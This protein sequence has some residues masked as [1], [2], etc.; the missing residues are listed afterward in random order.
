MIKF[1]SSSNPTIGVEIE[2]QIIDVNTLDLKNLAPKVLSDVDKK[3]SNRIKYELFESMIE[4]NSDICSSVTE[5][6]KD[7]TQS[8]HHLE[9]ILKGLVK[10]YK[11]QR[12]FL[13]ISF[14]TCLNLKK[15]Y[16]FC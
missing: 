9:E 11:L 10:L 16:H 2:L 7:I 14:D 8:L 4:I 15:S 13:K 5:V 1:N 6:E 3:F 12:L